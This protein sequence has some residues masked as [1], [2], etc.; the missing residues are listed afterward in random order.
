M[1]LRKFTFGPF[2]ISVH[3]SLA[4]PEVRERW[5][6]RTG[7]DHHLLSSLL[8]GL[9]QARPLDLSFRYLLISKEGNENDI[10]GIV[11]F[12]ALKFNYR[13][14]SVQGF[15][16]LQ[17]VV[18]LFLRFFSF[19]ILIG[20]NIFA[21]DFSPFS[22]SDK[23][24]SS[25]ELV[26]LLELYQ[27]FEKCDALVL[28]DLPSEFTPELMTPLGF[29]SFDADLTM[30]L[31]LRPEWKRFLD[32]EKALTHK[33]S[34]RARKV[35]KAGA[36]LIRRDLDEASCIDYHDRIEEL[37]RQVTRKQTIRMG[38][39]DVHYFVAIRHSFGVRFRMRGY[40]LGDKM[41]AFSSTILH[42]EKLEVHYIGIDYAYNRSHSLYFNILFDGVE[43][44]ILQGK[45]FLELGRTAREAKA[46]LGCTPLYFNDFVKLKHRSTRRIKDLVERYFLEKVGESWKT[47]NPFKPMKK[48]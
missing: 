9:E 5:D 17:R 23:K 7:P 45:R 32:Y 13:N 42:G 25:R 31:E 14:F 38:L 2:S 46:V 37:F 35:R 41:V 19:R 44:A 12:Q 26:Q 43:D 3:D 27:S 6:Q 11:Y 16:P 39:V 8:I 48:T 28:K 40:F 33:Y 20:G 22:Y 36:L 30:Q 47:R 4:E 29:D 21:V 24:I 18:S 1:L 15:A 34:Q 10:C